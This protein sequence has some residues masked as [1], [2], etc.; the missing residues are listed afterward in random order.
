MRFNK[1][2]IL[3]I[4]AFCFSCKNA[5]QD[6]SRL[7]MVKT[8]GDSIVFPPKITFTNYLS[9]TVDYY[10]PLDSKY[11]ILVYVDSTGCTNCKLHLTEWKE[12]KSYIDSVSKDKV[13]FLFFYNVKDYKR[14]YFM[15]K[16]EQFYYPICADY[17]DELNKI[18]NLV[19]G[20]KYHTL[21]LDRD[22]KII[23]IGN[24]IIDQEAK[25]FYLNYITGN[26]D[27]L[28]LRENEAKVEVIQSEIDLKTID[29]NEGK[30][31]IFYL[32]NIGNNP[33]AILY[34]N[35]SCGCT[36]ATF[37]NTKQALPGEILEVKVT[38]KPKA[39]GKFEE[40]ATV[41]CNTEGLIVLKV[42]GNAK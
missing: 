7:Q 41:K 24:P 20:D 27:K 16:Q 38:I 9:D 35:T 15:L 8:I 31:V 42:K 19:G 36:T 32:K 26:N 29:K 22:N 37:D 10:I 12:L 33:L 39:G 11:K 5:K 6:L 4:I 2:Y 21:L 1:L 18:N 40:T 17:D 13:E 25:E 3:A 30:E 34:I 28:I 23:A 14:L